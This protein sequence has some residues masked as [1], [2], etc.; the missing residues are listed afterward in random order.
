MTC[1]EIIVAYLDFLA[2]SPESFYV[3]NTAKALA[4]TYTMD[5]NTANKQ[6]AEINAVMAKIADATN[7]MSASEKVEY[8][9]DYLIA[10]VSY[11]TT[12]TA[13]SLHDALV[14][15]SAVCEGYTKA[16]QFIMEYLGV[17]C[18]TVTGK[19]MNH[20]WNVVVIDGVEYHVDV[21]WDDPI[22]NGANTNT[23]PTYD[24]FMKTTSELSEHYGF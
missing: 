21:T 22:V 20:A 24:F 8:V 5:A 6:N 16:F 17:S 11:V 12:Y 18:K 9:H 3:E 10:N 13:R 1:D 7:G 2:Q 4:I 23:T 19:A 14:N 15:G